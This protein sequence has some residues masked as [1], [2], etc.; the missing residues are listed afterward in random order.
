ME[1][2]NGQLIVEDCA[3]ADVGDQQGTAVYSYGDRVGDFAEVVLVGIW[4][5][6]LDHVHAA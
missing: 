4:D 6:Y 2:V 1:S 3:T 5:A